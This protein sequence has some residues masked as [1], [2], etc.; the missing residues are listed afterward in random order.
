MKR[1][2]SVILSMIMALA[3]FTACGEEETAPE[4]TYAGILTKIKL[5]MPL[6]KIISLQ[7]DGVELYYETDTR[8]WSQ[9]TDTDLMEIRDLIP[10]DNAY[11][12][13]DDSI[14]TYDFKT[15]KGDEE[16]YLNSYMS[17]VTCLLDRKTAEKYFVDKTAELA[18]KH[19]V[20]PVG[21]LKGTED[22]DMKLN[23]KQTYDCPSYKVDFVMTLTYQTVEGVDGYYASYFAVT[24]TEKEVKAET[25]IEVETEKE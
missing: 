9:N 13:V 17:E 4:S 5:G 6:T 15:V 16:I 22:I 12:Y 24:V 11:Y 19:A 7:P 25:A 14:I 2:I 10:E 21:T 1:I 3:C 8:I 18:K 23:Y 20:E